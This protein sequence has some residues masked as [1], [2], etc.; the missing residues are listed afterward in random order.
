MILGYVFLGHP[1]RLG[2]H[3]NRFN[4]QLTCCNLQQ[5]TRNYPPPRLHTLRGTVHTRPSCQPLKF[6]GPVQ[7]AWNKCCT[8]TRV[9]IQM[10]LVLRQPDYLFHHVQHS[11][12]ESVVLFG[13]NLTVILKGRKQNDV[14]THRWYSNSR[15]WSTYNSTYWIRGG[16]SQERAYVAVVVVL[17][18]WRGFQ[19]YFIRFFWCCITCLPKSLWNKF[20]SFIFCWPN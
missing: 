9:C 19:E 16:K 8:D 17:D 3:T 7:L 10:I 20:Q 15:Y 13:D 12:S 2:S 6:D 5:G 4:S 11:N 14:F 1:V 18:V